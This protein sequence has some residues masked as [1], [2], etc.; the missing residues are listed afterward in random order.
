MM[1]KYRAWSWNKLRHR[2]LSGK[3]HNADCAVVTAVNAYHVLTGKQAYRSEAAYKSLCRLAGAVYGSATSI[4]KV[5]DKLSLERLKGTYYPP[6]SIRLPVE[7]YV[8]HSKYGFHS[9]LA[10]ESVPKCEAYRFTN[11]DRATTNDGWI[12]NHDLVHFLHRNPKNDCQMERCR[13]IR[14]LR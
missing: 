6:R 4:E 9:V 13:C 8:W 12:F 5:Y 10:V 3:K 11:F 14:W 2:N 1:A 7:C